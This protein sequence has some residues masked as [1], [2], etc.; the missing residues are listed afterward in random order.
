MFEDRSS[1]VKCGEFGE[2]GRLAGDTTSQLGQLAS[3]SR[4]SM[5]HSIA[6]MAIAWDMIMITM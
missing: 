6:T 3:L 1:E 5:R 2:V 4:K